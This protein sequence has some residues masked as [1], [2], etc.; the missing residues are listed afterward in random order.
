MFSFLKNKWFLVYL[1]HYVMAVENLQ[2]FHSE[3]KLL[4]LYQE[5]Y[6]G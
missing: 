5:S 6:E 1:F 4:Q 2:L 3:K